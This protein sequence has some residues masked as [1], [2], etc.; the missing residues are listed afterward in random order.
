MA[1]LPKGRP[2]WPEFAF[3]TA[4]AARTLIAFTDCIVIFSIFSLISATYFAHLKFMIA[5]PNLLFLSCRHSTHYYTEYSQSNQVEF[6]I[7]L[8]GLQLPQGA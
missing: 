2:G 6:Y 8:Y 1:A 5:A 4:S 3:C 7:F